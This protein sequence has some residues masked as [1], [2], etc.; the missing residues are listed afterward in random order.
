LYSSNIIS[1]YPRYLANKSDPLVILRKGG[2]ALKTWLSLLV[3]LILGGMFL[4]LLPGCQGS[5]NVSTRTS[6]Q[7]AGPVLPLM[8]MEPHAT[9]ET[10]YFAMG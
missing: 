2:I 6:P 3:I 9:L 1:A 10:V 7:V 8:D 5:P 4:G